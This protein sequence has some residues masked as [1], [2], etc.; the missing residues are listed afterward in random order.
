M[1]AQST[2][3]PSPTKPVED[4]VSKVNNEVA[5]GSD[6]QFQRRWWK[7]EKSVWIVFTA[8]VILDLLGFFGRGPVANSH[9][10]TND[11]TVDVKYERIERFSTP[12]IMT[13]QFGPEAVH[14]GKLKL[15]VSESLVKALGAQRIVPQPSESVLGDG[16]VLYTFPATSG[17][18]TAEIALEP[19][20]PGIDHFRLR[21]PGREELQA[22]VYVMP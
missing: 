1:A 13:V 22:T 12:S 18:A 9:M 20:S 6:L 7:F 4:S 19:T 5:V 10:R 21:V 17:P 3:K 14:D 15:W 11:G 2:A 16:G 8:I